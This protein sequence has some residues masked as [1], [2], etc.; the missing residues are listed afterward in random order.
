MDKLFKIESLIINSENNS[1][2]EAHVS[3]DKTHR[4]FDGHF[5][6]QP[7]VPGVSYLYLIRKILEKY[8]DENLMLK[9]AASVKFLQPVN[10]EIQNQLNCRIT[11]KEIDSHQ[12]SISAEIKAGEDIV[13][14]M[15]GK[16][17]KECKMKNE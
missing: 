17:G 9:E 7:V 16:F 12:F 4:I 13:C 5:P 1:E 14:K 8:Y 15:K 3:I 10:P 2:I 6:G 11:I